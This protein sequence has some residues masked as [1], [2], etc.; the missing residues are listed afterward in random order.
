MKKRENALSQEVVGIQNLVLDAEDQRSYDE[1]HGI[2]SKHFLTMTKS[3]DTDW[4]M[5]RIK[6][7]IAGKIVVEIGAGVGIMA[8]EL[9]EYAKKIYA[10]E[11]DPAWSWAFMRHLYSTKPT[12]LTWILDSAVNLVDV[13]YADVAIVVTGSDELYLRELAGKFA[14]EVIMPWQD[15]NDNKAMIRQWGHYIVDNP[16]CNCMFG[17]AMYTTGRGEDIKPGESCK[18][19]KECRVL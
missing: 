10:I 9:A 14:P 1:K 7:R 18:L 2:G 19:R 3:E 13:I 4:I 11:A 12:N 5:A 6:D 17:C 16:V 15:W 8:L